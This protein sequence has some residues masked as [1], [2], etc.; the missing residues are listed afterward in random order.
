MSEDF[1]TYLESL[2]T[3]KRHKQTLL[4]DLDGGKP[5]PTVNKKLDDLDG[6]KLSKKNKIDELEGG[7]P[8][9]SKSKSSKPSKPSK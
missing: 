1:A 4:D 2:A 3:G 6:G 7:K 5:K 9:K 8:K